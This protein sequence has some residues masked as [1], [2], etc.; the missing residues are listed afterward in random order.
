M[1]K[2]ISSA[3]LVLLAAASFKT[4]AASRKTFQSFQDIAET[5]GYEALARL[6][7]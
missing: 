7:S 6:T 4:N 5:F 1:H 3:M 2:F